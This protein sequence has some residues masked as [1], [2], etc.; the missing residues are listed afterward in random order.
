MNCANHPDRERIAFCQDCGK[1]LCQ[2]CTRNVGSAV[3]C[4]ESLAARLAGAGVPPPAGASGGN[5]SGTFTST[6]TGGTYTYTGTAGDVN[7]TVNGVIPPPSL[8]GEPNPG[9]A[10][11][12]GFIPGVGAMYNG[13]YAKGVV[14]LVVF[15]ILI[16]LANENGIFGIFIAG[17]VC[18]QVIEAHHTARARRDGTPLP[19]PFG[20]NDL[21][22]RLGF[23]KA[24]PGSHPPYSTPPPPPSDSSVPP[25]GSTPYAATEYQTQ[26]AQQ[27]PYQTVPPAQSQGAAWNTPSWESYATPPIPPAQPFGAAAYPY[28]PNLPDPNLPIPRNRFP[29]GA[30]WLIG[31]GC[32]FLIGNA[33][34]FH[35][36]PVHRI[37]PF[38]LIGLGV[39]L[40]VHKMTETGYGLADDGTPVYQYRLFRAARGSIWVILV[41]VLFL[42]DSFDI[43]S[44]GRSWPLF[45]IVAGL[46]AVF[47]RASFHPP[48]V[49]YPYTAPPPAPAA[50]VAPVVPPT[51]HDQEG[52]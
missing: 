23:G 48:A 37:V 30:L 4:E 49:P 14:H 16:S 52:S 38:L 3:Y 33:G 25:S 27:A 5:P 19:N 26:S 13:Q 2:E 39:W 45:I 50:P 17:W 41:G 28:N 46:M 31:L 29:A 9:L 12:L 35:G 10:A 8:P 18:Y 6:P 20:L 7:Y 47:Q 34:L 43:L 42:L 36:F 15:V 1:P 11:L 40:F 21:S 24:W 32:I 22:E 44:W 51:S